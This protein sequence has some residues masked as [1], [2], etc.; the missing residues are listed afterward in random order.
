MAKNTGMGGRKGFVTDRVQK[1]NSTT[2]RWDKY[3]GRGDFLASKMTAGPWKSI[4][5]GK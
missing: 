5:K 4:R 1:F 2:K 3:N